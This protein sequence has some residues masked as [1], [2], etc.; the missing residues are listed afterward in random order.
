MGGVSCGTSLLR[1]RD[2][3]PGAIM[4]GECSWIGLRT[5]CGLEWRH[6]VKEIVRLAQY[7][8][9]VQCCCYAG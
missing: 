4:A 8:P 1:F 3:G 9:P 7:A 6:D 5:D 2:V